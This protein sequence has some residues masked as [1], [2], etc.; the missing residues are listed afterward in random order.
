MFE[1]LE[2][3]MQKVIRLLL[4]SL[5]IPLP[6]MADPI[7]F[8][9]PEVEGCEVQAPHKLVQQYPQYFQYKE[10]Q[11]TIQ[12]GK[13]QKSFIINQPLNYE[14]TDEKSITIHSYFPD[15]EWLVFKEVYDG[16]ESIGYQI[17]DIK[18]H[19][20]STEIN[21]PPH[22]SPDKKFF[23]NFEIDLEAGF[24]LNGLVIYRLGNAGEIEEVFRKDDEWG[25][26]A[27]KWISPAV[28]HFTSADYCDQDSR[29]ICK[30]PMKAEFKNNSWQISDR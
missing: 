15:L 1:L 26:T 8:C 2:I 22:L 3:K 17:V 29:E 12:S 4:T 28:I 21:T 6:L 10:P 9:E 14:S 30:K 27:A 7:V 16:G 20:K 11:L 25:V 24:L 23:M 5:L 19:L 13:I 18:H